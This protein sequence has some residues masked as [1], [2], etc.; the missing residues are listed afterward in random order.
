MWTPKRIVLLAAGFA[1]FFSGYAVYARFLGGIDGLPPLPERYLEALDPVVREVEVPQAVKHSRLEYKLK[2]AFGDNCVQLNQP[3]KLELHAKRTVLAAEEFRILAD[4]RAYLKPLSLALFGA[5]RGD[6]RGVEI[7]TLCADQAYL[8]FDR[9]V[10]NIGEI[11]SRKIIKA[12]LLRNIRVRNNRRTAARDDDLLVEIH[13]GPVYFDEPRH[14]IWTNDDVRLWDYQSKPKPAEIKGHGMEMEL[15]V[16][17]PAPGPRAPAGRKARGDSITGVKSIVLHSGVSM[18][19]YVDGQSGFPGGARGQPAGP[20]PGK[21]PGADA[22]AAPEKAHVVITAP[23]KFRYD[24]FKDYDLAR[25]DVAEDADGRSPQDV[26]AKRLHESLGKAD[27]LVCKHL[28]LRLRRKDGAGGGAS[29]EASPERNLEI[30]TA[31]ATGPDGLVVL[32]SDVENLSARGCDFFYDAPKMLTVLKGQPMME[33]DKDHNVIRARELRIEDHKPDAAGGKPYQTATALGPGTVDLIDKN[34]NP[35]RK[36][37]RA[38]WRDTL[39][40]TKDGAFDLLVFTGAASFLDYERNQTLD[41]ETL[42]VWLQPKEAGPSPAAAAPGAPPREPAPRP[43]HLEA[44]GNVTAH[45]SEMNVH[46]SG[47]LRVW[48]KDVPA[49][50][51]LPGGA[52]P[53]TLTSRTPAGAVVAPAGTPLPLPRGPAVVREA[54]PVPGAR[55]PGPG[56]LPAVA[57]PA[58]PAE[59]P[60]PI[61]LSARSVE[62]RVLRAGDRNVLDGLWCQGAVRVKQAPAKS[63]EKGVDIE[64]AELQMNAHPEGN[65]L[66]VRGDSEQQELAQLRMDKIYIVGPEVNIDQA[67]NKVWVNGAGVMQMESKTNFQGNELEKPVPLEVHWSKSML[68]DGNYAEFHGSIQAEQENA[69]LACQRLEVHFDRAISLKEGARG[70][71]PPARVRYLVCDRSVRVDEE[72]KVGD[73]VVKYQS[74]TGTWVTMRALEPDDDAPPAP[75][76][77]GKPAA[78]PNAGN[79]VQASGP[80]TVRILQAGGTDAPAPAARAPAPAVPAGGKPAEET[81]LTYV[82]FEARMYANSR[83]NK[84][85]FYENVRVLNFPCDNPLVPIDFDTFLEQM[86][87]GGMY[88][89]CDQMEVL[90]RPVTGGKGQQEMTATG[91]VVVQSKDFTGNAAKVTYN[92]EKD[93]IIFEG[94][95]GGSATLYKA[96]G[97]GADWKKIEG[98]KITYIRKTGEYKVDGVRSATGG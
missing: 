75:A 16:D 82:S 6:G 73:K 42:K 17:G 39:V 18:S 27:Q 29:V 53:A 90:N 4:G 92:E 5:D 83:K 61:D 66:V 11:G 70:D 9:A 2:Q 30:E 55:G 37:M 12:E 7:N 94:K 31:H 41:A 98:K 67:V 71:Q 69:H 1:F 51:R 34:A 36:V 95:D 65:V 33:A 93:Q 49:E 68:F 26:I 89:R 14:L 8:T 3:I 28:E 76:V 40:S 78:A 38:S 54:A 32:T 21:R 47:Q 52:T 85:V 72:T 46:D 64:G 79:E 57:G 97:K 77:P 19:L 24:V 63:D 59:P 13:P 50:P 62:A 96:E 88:L 23:G 44:I 45:S 60:R 91:H 35:Y 48:F 56:G 87:A 58:K 80:G 15:Q 86:P 84:A 22:A 81:K 43:D 10:T 74:L 20:A 25:F